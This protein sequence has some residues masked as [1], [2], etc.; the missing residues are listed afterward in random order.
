VTLNATDWHPAGHDLD[1]AFGT[2]AALDER[3]VDYL[4]VVAGQVTSVDRPSFDPTTL[5]DLCEAMR[6]E[7]ELPAM[8]TNYVTSFDEVNSLVG[9]AR[10]DLC[11]VHPDAFG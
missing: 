11:R 9:G 1:E 10:A 3:G 8:S 7:A 4:A 5:A 2:A 6:N